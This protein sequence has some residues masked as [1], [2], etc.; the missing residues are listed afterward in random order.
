MLLQDFKKLKLLLI[1]VEIKIEVTSFLLHQY[2]HG[3][4]DDM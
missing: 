2:F 3:R 1:C 4:E